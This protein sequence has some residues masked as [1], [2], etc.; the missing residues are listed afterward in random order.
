MG[1]VRDVVI[2][3]QIREQN[4]VD[5]ETVGKKRKVRM[6]LN[7]TNRQTVLIVVRDGFK[8]AQPRLVACT[9]EL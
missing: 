8:Y 4:P 3:N 9:D 1:T 5:W 6:G 7:A 2:F